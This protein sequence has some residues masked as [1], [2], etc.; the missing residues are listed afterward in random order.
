MQGKEIDS[1]NAKCKWK[2]TRRRNIEKWMNE[3]SG[4]QRA[5]PHPLKMAAKRA[6]EHV[7]NT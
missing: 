4:L 2:E 6:S 1:L 7:C 3:K 5:P